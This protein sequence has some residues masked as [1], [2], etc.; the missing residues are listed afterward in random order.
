MILYDEYVLE[1]FLFNFFSL[2]PRIWC[3]PGLSRGCVVDASWMR[4]GCV[5]VKAFTRREGIFKN[6]I[7]LT[8]SSIYTGH[9]EKVTH[10]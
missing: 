4:R 7:S 2:E 3:A 9:S 5:V 6:H 1:N 8:D 10:N